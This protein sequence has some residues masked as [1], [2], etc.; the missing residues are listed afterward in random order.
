LNTIRIRPERPG[1]VTE[2]GEITAAAFTPMPY[3]DGTEAGIIAAL[4]E[5][6]ALTLSLVATSPEGELVGQVTFSP[7][8]IDGQPGDWFGLGPV[9]VAPHMQGRGVGGALITQGLDRLRALGAA[10][11]VLLGNPS[12][13]SRFGFLSDPALTYQGKPNPY[14][15][16]LVLK[17]PPARG[18][19]SFHPAFDGP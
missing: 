12:Y 10:G 2:I 6:G 15:Q 5:A 14:F 4:R 8:Q 13:Y 1:D 18:D 16:R 9:S 3:A 7:V 11:C 19:V 17:G